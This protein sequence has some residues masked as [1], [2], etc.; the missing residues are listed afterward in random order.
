M[1]TKRKKRTLRAPN[2]QQKRSDIDILSLL[3]RWPAL[4][5][6]ILRLLTKQFMNFLTRV[7]LLELDHT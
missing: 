6:E 2:M 4:M 5:A 7:A 1:W 3:V